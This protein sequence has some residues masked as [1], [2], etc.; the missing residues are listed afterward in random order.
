VT[1]ETGFGPPIILDLGT[2]LRPLGLELDAAGAAET[3]IHLT[4]FLSHLHWDH[5][6]GLPFFPTVHHPGTRL[7]VYGPPQQG[8]SLH[9]V[10]ER[11]LHPPFFPINV[12]GLRGDVRFKEALDEDVMVGDAKVVVRQVPHVG[13][14][15]GFRV[16]AGGAAVAF[17]SDHQQPGN[18]L[19]VDEKVLEL[20]DGADLVIHD[21]QYTPEEFGFKSDWGH[22]TIAY[23]VHVAREAGARQLALFH[24]DPLHVDDDIDRL[25]AA[26]RSTED[27]SHLDKVLAASEGLSLEV[28]PSV[29]SHHGTGPRYVNGDRTRNGDRRTNGDRVLGAFRTPESF[30]A[31]GYETVV[32]G[33][34]SLIEQLKAARAGSPQTRGHSSPGA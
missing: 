31:P 33:G 26:A 22:S 1:V 19:H 7:E 8:G 30:G 5:I 24:H 27:A 32:P 21:A 14:T 15:L 25:L 17:V 23:A 13:T 11:V 18:S 16:E 2:G 4:A 10:F 34:W 3:G 20:C 28:R 6:I 29:S 9:D 12:E